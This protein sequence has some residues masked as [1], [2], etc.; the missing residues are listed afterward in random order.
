MNKP[1]TRI[2]VVFLSLIAFL[3]GVRFALALP[4]TI[5]GALIPV[6]ASAVACV[7]VGVLAVMTWRELGR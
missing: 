6:W 2:T 3:Q 5:A 1:F 4:V 7:V